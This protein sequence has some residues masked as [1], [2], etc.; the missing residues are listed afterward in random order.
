VLF[1]RRV[2]GI[3]EAVDNGFAE[4][5]VMHVTILVESSTAEWAYYGRYAIPESS[6]SVL[7][8]RC[9]SSASSVSDGSAD[10]SRTIL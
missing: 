7:P 6:M 2:G 1:G 4:V 3:D 8:L 5:G 9:A 10:V